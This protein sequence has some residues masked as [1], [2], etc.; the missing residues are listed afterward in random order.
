MEIASHL[1]GPTIGAQSRRILERH[2]QRVAFV[3]ATGEHTYAEVLDLIGRYQAVLAQAGLHRGDGPRRW[4]DVHSAGHS[5]AGV[6]AVRPV[7]QIIDDLARE[8]TDA[9]APLGDG[10]AP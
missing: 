8:Y 1:T 5:V 3:D 10:A 2:P 6:R 4:A 7:A 9:L